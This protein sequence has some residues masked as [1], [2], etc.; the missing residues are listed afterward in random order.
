VALG[1]I[2]KQEVKESEDGQSFIIDGSELEAFLGMLQYTAY[3][4]GIR[5]DVF[6]FRYGSDLHF[7]TAIP[8]IT[9]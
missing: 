5:P 8:N 1:L 9:K 2:E 6:S 7:K 3:E 4:N